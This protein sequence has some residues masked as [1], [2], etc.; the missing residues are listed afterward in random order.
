MPLCPC[1]KVVSGVVVYQISDTFKAA[2]MTQNYLQFI[3][4]QGT[5]PLCPAP[6]LPF[7]HI[8]HYYGG[9]SFHTNIVKILEMLFKLRN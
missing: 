3:E 9:V 2:V 4:T 5:A 8:P 7:N 1:I 6:P